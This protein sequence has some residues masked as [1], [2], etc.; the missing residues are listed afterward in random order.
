MYNPQASIG[1]SREIQDHL[2]PNPSC[3]H[4]DLQI[5]VW[6]YWAQFR[7]ETKTMI[8]GARLDPSDLGVHFTEAS[9]YKISVG[10]QQ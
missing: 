8:I 1:L 3:N 5:L 6:T 7:T 9:Y 4:R 2:N 10:L